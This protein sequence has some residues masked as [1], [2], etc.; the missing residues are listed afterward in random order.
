LKYFDLHCD[1][2]TDCY[3]DKK[4]LYDGD[5]QISLMRGKKYSPWFQCFAIWITDD[6]RG[7]AALDHFDAIF[8]NLK[9]EIQQHSDSIMLCKTAA[10]F[11]TA[12][13]QHKVGAVLT[14]EGGAAAAG[15]L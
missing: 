8:L 9:K 12:E 3:Q 2:I 13:Q 14:V 7:Q 4:S 5:L 11:K 10:D 15:S 6:R 1:T